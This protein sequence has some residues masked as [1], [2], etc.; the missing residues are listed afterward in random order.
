[1]LPS[2]DVDGHLN[3][4]SE[5]IEDVKEDGIGEEAV[6]K[7]GSVD[8]I[9]EQIIGEAPFS[10]VARNYEKGKEKSKSYNPILFIFLS[11]LLV[12]AFALIFVLYVILFSVII[13]I[14]AIFVTFVICAVACFVWG[15]VMI[16][17]IF[18]LLGHRWAQD[19][20]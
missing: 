19:F 6:A 7:I 9:A 11:P 8:G 10:A 16:F 4:Y 1:M 5:M 18:P 12:I 20:F 14:W 3:F 2:D 17:S 13:S 15:V